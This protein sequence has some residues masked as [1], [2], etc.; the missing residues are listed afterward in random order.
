MGSLVKVNENSVTDR[1]HVKGG[2]P[3]PTL[4]RGLWFSLCGSCP[5]EHTIIVRS[6]GMG[7]HGGT[8]EV[9]GGSAVSGSKMGVR[10][11]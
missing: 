10:P 11:G 4:R 3:H 9:Y 8:L 7:L 6:W 1:D 5:V 2:S